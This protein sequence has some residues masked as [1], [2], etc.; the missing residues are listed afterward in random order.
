M[1][2]TLNW[3]RVALILQNVSALGKVHLALF[4]TY[5]RF[6]TSSPLR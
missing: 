5:A 4:G 6:K 1:H 3:A 2:D